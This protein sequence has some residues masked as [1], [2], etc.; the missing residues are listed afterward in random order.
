M[1]VQIFPC[2]GA[3]LR[4]KGAVWGPSAVSCGKKAK[5]IEMLFRVDLGGPN[6]ACVKWGVHIGATW[7]IR[8]YRL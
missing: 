5:P 1:G 2:E 3:I 6:E 8:L 7:L 4:R